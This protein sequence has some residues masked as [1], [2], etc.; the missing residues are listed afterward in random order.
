MIFRHG[1]VLIQIFEG[2]I[3]EISVD[4]I[5]NPAN[6]QLLMG[7]GV[8]GAIKRKGGIVIEKE[9]RKMAPVDI[10]DA[11]V[12][13]A[14]KLPA[15]W[16]IHAPTVRRPAGRASFESVSLATKAALRAAEKIGARSVA[17]PAMGAGVGGLGI[18]EAVQAML[19]EITSH[20]DGG[21]GLEKIILVA[22]G[23]KALKEFMS[24][25]KSVL[26]PYGLNYSQAHD[27]RM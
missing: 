12:T 20:I 13:S 16:V 9:A 7:G 27:I 10:G 15:K 19:A 18:A 26:E 3:T 22:W 5:V 17:F 6:S 23:Q 14:G 11:V 4:A 8:A 21:T 2:D 25:A 24:A 1:E